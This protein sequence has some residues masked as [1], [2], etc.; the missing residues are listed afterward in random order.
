M[1]QLTALRVAALALRR[2]SAVATRGWRQL[3]FHL[4]H[5]VK[6]QR[7]LPVTTGSS[8]R[9]SPLQCHWTKHMAETACTARA[10]HRAGAAAHPRTQQPAL[11]RQHQCALAPS[12]RQRNWHR[13][14]W[15]QR[16]QTATAAD[17][18]APEMCVIVDEHN[19]VVGAATRRETVSKRLLGRGAYVLVFDGAGRLFVSKRSAAKDCYPGRLDVTVSGVVNAGEE[20]KDT[21][22]RELQEEI[23]VPAR[24]AAAGL[25]R[26]FVF[27]YQVRAGGRA[28]RRAHGCAAACMC[29][30]AARRRSLPPQQSERVLRP[31]TP[32]GRRLPCVGLRVP[33][34]VG[35]P[36]RV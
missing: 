2:C 3:L 18:W 30:R 25:R 23:G 19:N 13:G 29:V 7:A 8:P 6:S 11:W 33:D 17:A 32:T 34:D 21:A 1:R 14:A 27:P 10:A 5:T 9:C 31:W 36:H 28:A 24:E 20:Y 35:R 22:A 4:P 15:R 16:T 12:L 26:L